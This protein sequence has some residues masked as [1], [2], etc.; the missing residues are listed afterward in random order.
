MESIFLKNIR[1]Y[2]FHGCLREEGQ[3]GSDYLVNLKVKGNFIGAASSDNLEETIDYVH[4][5][6][7]VKEEMAQRSKLIE[8]VAKRIVDRIFKEIDLAETVKISVSKCNPPIGGN[9]QE[10]AVVLNQKR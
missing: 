4:L 8:T 2:G 5:N 3:I 9:V 1:I 7:I 6:R 10:V